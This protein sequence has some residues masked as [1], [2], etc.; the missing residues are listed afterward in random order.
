M[1]LPTFPETAP[2]FFLPLRLVIVQMRGGQLI[3]PC[4]TGCREERKLVESGPGQS[5]GNKD[6]PAT[7]VGWVFESIPEIEVEVQAQGP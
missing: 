5:S 6:S 2:R 7:V 4:F 1:A 3:P